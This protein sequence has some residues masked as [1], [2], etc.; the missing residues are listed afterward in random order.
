[1][2]MQQIYLAIPLLPLLA[3]ILVGLFGK[4]MPRSMAHIL[5]IAGVAVS[6]T[7]SLY[8]LKNAL[9][10]EPYNATVYSWLKSG[11]F[12]FEI[13]FLIDRLS[14]MMMVV[15]TFVSL[16]VHIYTIG[17]M[18]EDQ[19]YARFFS[20]ISLFTFAMLMLV[21]SNNF[22]QLFFGWEAV[23]LVS[24]LLIGF[25]YTRP[26]TIYANLKAFL[27]NRVNDFGF[28]LNIDLVLFHFGS[29]DYAAVFSVAPQMADVQINLVGNTQWSLMTATCILLFIGAMGKSAQVPL[30]V[31]LPD[32]MEGPTPISALIHAATMVTAGIFMEA[33]MSP[34]F[35]LSTNE[36]AVVDNSNK[37]DMRVTMKIPAV[38]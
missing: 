35:E 22:M 13:G 3:A 11:N 12:T 18:H 28:L 8:V 23:G 10:S 26:T 31:W 21:M 24:Y 2:T 33:R 5:T 37:G 4:L 6:F 20:Y 34:L 7:L 30:H 17:Y 25:W 32:S 16:M 9:V 36:S 1:M 29:L 19:G 27:V 14:A 38:T 15:V